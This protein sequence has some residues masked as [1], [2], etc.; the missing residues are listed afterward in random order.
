MTTPEFNN[1]AAGLFTAR[2]AQANLVTKTHFDTKLKCLSR[3]INSNKAKHL[4]VENEPK[5][6]Q[7]I[8]MAYFRG[9]NGFEGND[10]VQNL[11][12]LQLMSK[13]L[14]TING[15]ITVSEWRSKGIYNEVLK[16]HNTPA[17]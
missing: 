6:L 16:V 10:G 17:A 11:L 4:L 2:L 7:K 13:Y 12:I 3:T 9:R 8:Y 5:K 1:L 14:K 15:N